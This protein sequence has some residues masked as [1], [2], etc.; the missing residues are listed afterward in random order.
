MANVNSI[1]VTV[2][3]DGTW[4]EYWATDENYEPG[5]PHGTG[6]T[7]RAALDDYLEK[8][9]E[10]YVVKWGDDSIISLTGDNI[11]YRW[12]GPTTK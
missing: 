4:S 3:Y 5:W 12:T 7:I 11:E 2:K 1:Q 10:F 8:A 6:K 9:W